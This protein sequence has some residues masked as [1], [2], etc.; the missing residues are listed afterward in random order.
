MCTK[1]IIIF[2]KELKYSLFNLLIK[3][4]LISDFL[5]K[6]VFNIIQFVTLFM[7]VADLL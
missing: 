2:L 5:F 7:I 3:L 4:I 6:Y 1:I